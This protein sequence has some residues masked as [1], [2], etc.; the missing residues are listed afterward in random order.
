MSGSQA[1]SRGAP[2]HAPSTSRTPHTGPG[3]R[4]LTHSIPPNAISNE[5]AR[6]C[7]RCILSAPFAV[8]LDFFFL[9]GTL[10]TF[11]WNPQ[12]HVLG[13]FFRRLNLR[14][15]VFPLSTEDL[16]RMTFG[17]T[18]WKI[19]RFSEHKTRL[20]SANTHQKA[21][22]LEVRVPPCFNSLLQVIIF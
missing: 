17:V 15:F 21:Q 18:D 6:I 11:F 5:Y 2:W 8:H 14:V 19:R 10:T 22:P 4:P 1:K 3:D 13:I 16:T 20:L 7:V 9:L 12:K